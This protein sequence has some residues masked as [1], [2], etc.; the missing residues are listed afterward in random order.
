M[1]LMSPRDAYIYYFKYYLKISSELR[2]MVLGFWVSDPLDIV[3]V[4]YRIEES[5]L[6]RGRACY[7]PVE[8]WGDKIPNPPKL[9]TMDP[10]S[11]VR[12]L[13]HIDPANNAIHHM[14]MMLAID[15]RE[16][17]EIQVINNGIGWI[18]EPT[19]ILP[20]IYK[21]PLD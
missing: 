20:G 4:V 7:E 18:G 19:D 2:N 5:N 3:Q 17:S 1:E 10:D 8:D 12:V 6:L 11:I 21:V 14:V 16:S 15:I 9:E 13:D